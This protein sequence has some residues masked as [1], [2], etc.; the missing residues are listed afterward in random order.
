MVNKC[1]AHGCKSADKNNYFK[2]QIFMF[3]TQE[4]L[5]VNRFRQHQ[6]IVLSPPSYV[7]LQN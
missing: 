3:P 5:R 6:E 7:T 1:A 4:P 2:E